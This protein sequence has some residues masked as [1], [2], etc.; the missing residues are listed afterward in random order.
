MTSL[1]LVDGLPT[2]KEPWD[3]KLR[4]RGLSAYVHSPEFLARFSLESAQVDWLVER[5]PAQWAEST[6]KLPRR[7]EFVDADLWI[8]Q[9]DDVVAE[10]LPTEAGEV[11]VSAREARTGEVLWERFIPIPEAADWAEPSPAWPGA[12]TEEIH[13][14]F[15]DDPRRL[16]FCLFRETRRH[17]LVYPLKGIEVRSLPPY[18]CQTD[19]VR[20]DPLSGAD[21]WDGNFPGVHVG[22]LGRDSFT[23]AWSH[24][25]QLGVL[26][27]ETGINTTL[28]ESSHALGWPARVDRLL[29]VPWHADKEVGVDWIDGRGARV[30]QGKW[31]CSRVRHTQLHST[32][33]GLALQTNDQTL[34]WLGDDE[35]PNWQIRAKPYI[36]NVHGLPAT[37]IFVGTDGQGG[38]M[39][40]FDQAT[41]NETLNLKPPCGGA[42]TFV[43]LPGHDVLMGKFWTAKRDGISGRVCVISMH[44]RTHKLSHDCAAPIGA[45]QHGIVCITGRNAERLGVVDLRD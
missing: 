34:W 39:L 22:I 2:L 14:F 18:G 35:I 41:G 6:W 32:Q 16:V 21:L 30:R 37:D 25:S 36:Y 38:R 20:F 31:D 45:W 3:L 13:P 44:D 27:F 12:Q 26:D 43:A 33:A 10:T 23:G 11:I 1:R 15:G 8:S 9:I 19:A 29:A 5:S 7:I 42:G 24:G 40:A 28:F 4:T 17:S